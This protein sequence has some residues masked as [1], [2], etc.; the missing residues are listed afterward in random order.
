MGGGLG[1]GEGSILLYGQVA[2][3]APRAG[4]PGTT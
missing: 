3:G 1:R 4:A 2:G